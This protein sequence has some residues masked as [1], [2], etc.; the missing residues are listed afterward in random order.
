MLFGTLL[1]HRIER[2]FEKK[3]RRIGKNVFWKVRKSPD[4]VA[5]SV[6]GVGLGGWLAGLGRSAGQKVIEKRVFGS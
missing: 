4:L 6:L 1:N 5:R 3:F 2:L